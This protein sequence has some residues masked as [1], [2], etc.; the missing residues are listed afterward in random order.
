MKMFL[1]ARLERLRSSPRPLGGEG[2]GVRGSAGQ[3]FRSRSASV[4]ASLTLLI[5]YF[6][7]AILA[8]TLGQINSTG[9]SSSNN[10][11]GAQVRGEILDAGGQVFNVKAYGAK[12]DGKA[13]DTSAI[14][15]AINAAGQGIVYFPPGT[16]LY[17]TLTVS[18]GSSGTI[19]TSLIG[20]GS[21]A[22][23]LR[24]KS[25]IGVGV[26]YCWAPPYQ[27][28][29]IRGI[30]FDT[31][32]GPPGSVALH[33]EDSTGWTIRD[34]SFVGTGANKDIGIEFEN[35]RGFNERHQVMDNQFFEDD[36]SIKFLQDPGD[37]AG[38]SFAYLYIV[39][40]HFQ[41]PS[42]G[43][44]LLADG[45]NAGNAYFYSSRID[46]HANFDASTGHLIMLQNKLAAQHLIVRL[47]AENGGDGVCTDSTSALGGGS[48]MWVTMGKG[49]DYCPG[50]AVD[51]AGPLGGMADS[52]ISNWNG[53]GSGVSMWPIGEVSTPPE[54]N[55]PVFSYFGAAVGPNLISPF[56]TMYA[57]PGN[58][59]T[60][61]T[62]GYGSNLSHMSPVASVDSSGNGSFA[63]GIY[64]GSAT[65]STATVSWTHGAAVPSGACSNGSLYSNTAGSRGS[66]LYV[67]VSGKWVDVE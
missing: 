5:R 60:I 58:A 8:I 67:C 61:G 37:R 11:G 52:G 39:R 9:Q 2:K 66:T 1:Q 23:T 40:D 10:A 45:G 3:Y 43:I 20:T 25:A 51:A 49:A 28:G 16:Y 27:G 14:Q 55:G 35:R 38:L 53:T 50:A 32:A 13:D 22:T 21:N 56:V 30:R 7:I 46:L 33:I 24:Q 54:T 12:G 15:A 19:K 42:G 48:T 57:N 63:G 59:F 65:K 34:N 62:I 18:G 36:P 64:L 17:S 44:G 47:Q 26:D 31:T 4:C 41:I 29:T 6:G